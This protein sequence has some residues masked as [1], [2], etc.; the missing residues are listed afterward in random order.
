M[1]SFPKLLVVTGLLNTRPGVSWGGG[2]LPGGRPSDSHQPQS[3]LRIR[4][5]CG[6]P[7][8]RRVLGATY[9]RHTSYG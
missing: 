8:K 3:S 5:P 2:H 6:F 1:G 9:H 7:V 4:G